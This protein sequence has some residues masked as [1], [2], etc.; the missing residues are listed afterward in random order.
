V[1]DETQTEEKI[2]A[3]AQEIGVDEE[4]LVEA[5]REV[6]AMS[7]EQFQRVSQALFTL[8]NQLSTSAYQNIQQARFITEHKQ[9]EADRARFADRLS[10]AAKIAT[11]VNTILDPDELLQ[12][13]ILLIKERF[14]LYHVQVY[15]MDETE[16]A[17]RLQAGY[18]EPGRIM[19]RSRASDPVGCGKESGGTFS[20]DER[21]STGRT[22]YG[23]VRSSYRIR[24]CPI[25]VRK[26]RCP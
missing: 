11:Q 24:Y 21:S 25:P 3:Y 12:T 26:W 9:V 10:V 4:T 16:K 13:V 7:H 18:G 19:V 20:P 2:R 1:R 17:L 8:A 15:T 6:P 23:R 14:A 22:T 5:F